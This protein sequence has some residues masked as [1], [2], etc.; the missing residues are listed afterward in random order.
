MPLSRIVLSAC[1][2]T[3]PV[4]LQI[5]PVTENPVLP[6]SDAVFVIHYAGTNNSFH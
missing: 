1:C 4:P 5:C 6:Y 2:I 3:D